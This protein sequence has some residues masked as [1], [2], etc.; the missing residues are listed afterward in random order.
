MARVF[1]SYR[2]GASASASRLAADLR[3]RGHEVWVREDAVGVGDS[4][5]ER[6]TQGL[7]SADYLVLCLTGSAEENAWL[8]REWQSTLARQLDG[9]RI[10]LLPAMFS[11]GELPAI[12][13]DV[14]YADFRKNWAAGLRDL[15]ASIR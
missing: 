5:V 6:V 7:G 12:L 3:D 1:L 2:P 10:G 11:G 8:N 15:L 14:R 4:I 9:Y 13:A